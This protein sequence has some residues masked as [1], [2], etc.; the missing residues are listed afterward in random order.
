MLSFI[1]LRFYTDN[2]QTKMSGSKNRSWK[3]LCMGRDEETATKAEKHFHEL[4]YSNTKIIGVENDKVTDDHLIELLKG[5][6]W[7]GISIGM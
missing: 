1:L 2:K 7:D 5:N 6:D 3:V 4:G